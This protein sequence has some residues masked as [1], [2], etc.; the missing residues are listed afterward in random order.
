MNGINS[1]QLNIPYGVPQGSVLGPL[2]FL[3][4][5]NDLPK[6]RKKLKFYLFVDDTNIYIE[7]QTLGKLCKKVDTELKYVKRWLD[8]NK[9]Q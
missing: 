8:A 9:L 7:S 3:I 5:I 1:D 4:F 6:T 2:L